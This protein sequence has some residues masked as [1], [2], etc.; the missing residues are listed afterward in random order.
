MQPLDRTLSLTTL[1]TAEPP[2]SWAFDVMYLI[3]E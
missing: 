2:C 1:S 3:L